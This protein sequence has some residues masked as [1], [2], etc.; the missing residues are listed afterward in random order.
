[1]AELR[2]TAKGVS[3]LQRAFSNAPALVESEM[4]ATMNVSVGQIERVVVDNTPVGATGLARGSMTTDV[5]GSGINLTGRVFSRDEPIKIASLETGRAPG[6]MPPMAP[7]ELWVK[8]KFGGDRSAAFLV[9][10]AIGRRGTKG[11][12]MFERAFDSESPRIK[13]LWER[14]IA[15]IVKRAFR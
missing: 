2:I 9:A 6:K 1:M 14:R 15:A 11:A 3:E 4:R 7:I 5:S 12:H 13:S 8:R 10:R